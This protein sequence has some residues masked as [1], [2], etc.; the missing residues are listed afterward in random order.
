MQAEPFPVDVALVPED[1]KRDDPTST[2][3]GI[4]KA[5]VQWNFKMGFANGS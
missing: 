5:G 1:G 2:P 3:Y 4:H